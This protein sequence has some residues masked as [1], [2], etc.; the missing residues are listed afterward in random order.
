MIP[1][2]TTTVVL[3]KNT[4]FGQF[5]DPFWQGETPPND[6]IHT[7][8]VH[9]VLCCDDVFLVCAGNLLDGS[10]SSK[11]QDFRRNA[12]PQRNLPYHWHYDK[13][14]SSSNTRVGHSSAR[15]TTCIQTTSRHF[16]AI[17][18]FVRHNLG[19]STT[20]PHSTP[21]KKEYLV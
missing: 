1:F 18:G 17:M 4:V 8:V 14:P 7:F 12:S 13:V 11:C 3:A 9:S 10:P 21:Q 20:V 5:L 19:S 15:M 2:S 16:L 6:V